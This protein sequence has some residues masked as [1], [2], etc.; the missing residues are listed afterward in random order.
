MQND[1][2]FNNAIDFFDDGRIPDKI[3]LA[4]S[5]IAKLVSC[6]ILS[7]SVHDCMI[8]LHKAKNSL[9]YQILT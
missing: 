8:C 4:L 9:G 1:M 3:K 2:V 5:T 6:R 7:D